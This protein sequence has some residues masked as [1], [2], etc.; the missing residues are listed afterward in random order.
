MNGARVY[1]LERRLAKFEK[2]LG[3]T[4][5]DDFFNQTLRQLGELPC[6]SASEAFRRLLRLIQTAEGKE[7]L[8]AARFDNTPTPV[9]DKD[10]A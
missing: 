9:T 10:Q 2:E 7:R 5:A 8:R 1:S 3:V 6:A 4:D